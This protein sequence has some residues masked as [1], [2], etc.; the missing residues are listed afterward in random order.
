MH[1]VVGT[2][3]VK[4]FPLVYGEVGLAGD[5]ISI[6]GE[7]IPV[8]RG[9]PALLAAAI[10]TGEYLGLPAPYGYLAGD[11]GRGNGS[12]RIYEHLAQNLVGL[13]ARTITFHYLQPDVDW[14]NKV[15][16]AVE[17]MPHR[18]TLIADAGYMYAAKMSGKAAL[19]DLFTPDIGELAFLADEMAPHP[20][21]TRGFILHEENKV[22]ELI[23]RSYKHDNAARYLLVKGEKD[24][25]ANNKGVQAIV[26][27]PR[28][29]AMTAIGGTGDTLTGI[30]TALIEVGMDIIEAATVAART[31]RLAGYHAKPTPAT[32]VTEIVS[33][34]PKGLEETL[35][36]HGK[37]GTWEDSRESI[38]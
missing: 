36:S 30:I 31:N 13:D 4:D 38:G 22:P 25:I 16:F 3:P 10:K 2:V 20:F 33:R 24:Y 5:R 26:E 19:Y 12:I 32:Q 8:N 15:L 27:Q 35:C 18:P 7:K 29:E 9:T 21:Y 11:I 37:G 1:V 6:G 34:I 17:E 14:H 28:E 23:A